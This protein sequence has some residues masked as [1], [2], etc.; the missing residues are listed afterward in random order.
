VFLYDY[1]LGAKRQERQF[2]NYEDSCLSSFL[3]LDPSYD[4]SSE[5]SRE[6]VKVETVDHFVSEQSIDSVDLLKVD[7]QGFD[8]EVL[9]GA[10]RALQSGLVRNVLIELNFVKMYEGQASSADIISTLGKSGLFLLDYYE[11]VRRGHTLA[12]CNGLFG[13]R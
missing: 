2:I 8:L 6:L 12:W 11:K 13:R 4:E 5:S 10:E 1:A 3:P 7:T 9:L